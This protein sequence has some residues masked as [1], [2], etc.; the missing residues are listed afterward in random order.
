MALIDNWYLETAINIG[1]SCQLLTD[2]MVDIFIVDGQNVEDVELQLVKC[3]ESLRGYTR[4]QI[5]SPLS[6]MRY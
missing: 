3:R 2:D 4:T 1:Y 5:P 6:G